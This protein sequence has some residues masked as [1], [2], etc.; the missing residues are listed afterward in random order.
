MQRKHDMSRSSSQAARGPVSLDLPPDRAFVLQF[1][2]RAQLPRR[3]VGRVEHVSS[4]RVT[5]V[6]SLRELMAFLEE[7]LRTTVQED[8]AASGDQPMR[9]DRKRE[10]KS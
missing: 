7:V 8:G 1:D 3:M 5:H 2:V 6:N 10:P 9:R 4:G